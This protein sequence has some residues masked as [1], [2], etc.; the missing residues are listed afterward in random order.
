MQLDMET[1]VK[2]NIKQLQNL[3]LNFI[4]TGYLP[5]ITKHLLLQVPSLKFRVANYSHVQM[6]SCA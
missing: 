2:L 4:I 6:Y 1:R 5:S 3:L